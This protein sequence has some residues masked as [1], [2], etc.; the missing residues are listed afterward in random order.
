MGKR[1][2]GGRGNPADFEHAVCIFG[3]GD[4]GVSAAGGEF[5]TGFEFLLTEAV[6]DT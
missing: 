2:S 1:Y 6:F 5:G 3:F 4:G